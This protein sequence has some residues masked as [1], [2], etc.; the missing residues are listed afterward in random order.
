MATIVRPMTK[1][2]TLSGSRTMEDGLR[3]LRYIPRNCILQTDIYKIARDLYA[4]CYSKSET[5]V[6]AAYN[7][8]LIES[9][10]LII[11]SITPKNYTFL[12]EAK[13]IGSL[14]GIYI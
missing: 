2:R 3:T 12:L 7:T 1:A 5:T 6:K 8:Y 14:V 10:G 11:T 13:K 4:T 9:N